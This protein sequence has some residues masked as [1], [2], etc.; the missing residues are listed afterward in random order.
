MLNKI[1]LFA[2]ILFLSETAF[3]ENNN[4]IYLGNAPADFEITA[5]AGGVSPAEPLYKIELD[6]AG[7][8]LYFYIP[9]DKRASGEFIKTNEFML[10]KLVLDMIYAAIVENDFFKLNKEYIAKDTLDGSFAELTVT[11]NN[12]T[13]TVRT[14]NTAQEDFDNIIMTINLVVPDDNKIIYNELLD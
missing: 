2:L 4:G 11:A 10:D 5:V 8:G 7:K 3:A 1:L 9:S 6:P 14:Q 12:K 13:H